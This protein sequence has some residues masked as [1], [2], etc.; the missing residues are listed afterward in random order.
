MIS[1]EHFYRS[2]ICSVLLRMTQKN[3]SFNSREPDLYDYAKITFIHS[4]IKL[5]DNIHPVYRG[6]YTAMR[7]YEFYLRVV[8]TIYM[9]NCVYSHFL[10]VWRI[11]PYY[12]SLSISSV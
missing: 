6:Y 7:R 5:T 10:I 3:M 1:T 8:K 4:V 12:L 11:E 2:Y 9:R